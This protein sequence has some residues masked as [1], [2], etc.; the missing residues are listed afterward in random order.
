[1]QL[2]ATSAHVAQALGH[3]SDPITRRHYLAPGTLEASR[4]ARLSVV[5]SEPIPQL[6]RKILI[7]R[8]LDEN[9]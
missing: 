7:F 5:C 3:A 2:G 8:F 6:F 4:I 1:V 9:C